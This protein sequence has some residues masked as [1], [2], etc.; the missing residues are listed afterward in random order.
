MATPMNVIDPPNWFQ[1]GFQR[2]ASLRPVAAVLRPTAH[3]LDAVTA[4]LFNGRTVSG[5]LAGIPNIFLTTTGARSG[6]P[7]TVPLVG[8]NIDGSIAIIG[9]RFG[10]DRHPGW[11][12]N[13]LATPQATVEVRGVRTN[14]VARLVDDPAEYDRIMALADAVYTGYAKYRE[15]ITAREI[16]VFVLDP[17][18]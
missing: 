12:F 2:F 6:E 5:S 17:A 8:L 18:G 4:K 9:T 15:R 11:Y 14:V 16:P 3:R 1:R 10:S 13:L 7:R